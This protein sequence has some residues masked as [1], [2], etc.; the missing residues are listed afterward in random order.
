MDWRCGSHQKR[1]EGGLKCAE[2]IEEI[3]EEEEEEGQEMGIKKFR[4]F[5]IPEM[6]FFPLVVCVAQLTC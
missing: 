3:E 1:G 5:L 2:E 6:P 4:F